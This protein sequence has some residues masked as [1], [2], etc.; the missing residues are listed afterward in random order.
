MIG[1]IYG[2][3]SY[4]GVDHVLIDVNG[5]GYEVYLSE[6]TLAKAPQLG[7]K[8]SVYTE[9]IVREDLLQLVGFVSRY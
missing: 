5:V 3:L 6:R 9:L 2:I 1:K 7:E 8:I 4:K